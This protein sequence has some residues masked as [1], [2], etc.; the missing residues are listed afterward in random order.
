[1]PKSIAGMVCRRVAPTTIHLVVRDLADKP[2]PAMP[3]NG[4]L[5]L[6]VPGVSAVAALSSMPWRVRTWGRDE[7]WLH[8]LTRF[9][10]EHAFVMTPRERIDGVSSFELSPRSKS[11][12]DAEPA[13]N[14][15]F[16]LYLFFGLWIF[17]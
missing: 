5:A 1:M 14:A 10:F 2:P 17:V 4:F 3:P 9:C 11:E 6:N 8:A 13:T 7:V 12:F 15:Y 16:G